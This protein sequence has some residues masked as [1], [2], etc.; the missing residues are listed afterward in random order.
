MERISA[1]TDL[2]TPSGKFRYGSEAGG[3]PATPV[4]AEWLNILQEE[5]CNFVLAFL[6]SLDAADNT[7]LL[8]AVR[9][10]V[11]DYYTKPET[12]ALIAAV[13][14]GSP[15]A[16]NTLRKLAAA[17]GNDPNF[18]TSV[19]TRFD[20]LSTTVN[21][22]LT[23]FSNTVTGWLAE[24]APLASPVFTGQPKAPT[25][26]AG[27]KSKLLATTEYVQ[28]A[29]AAAH[30]VGSLYFNASNSANPLALL[31]FGTWQALGAGR[32]L[33]GVGTGT[34]ARGEARAFAAGATG[35]EYSHVLTAAEMPSHTHPSP[36]GSVTPTGAGNYSSGD[37]TTSTA[38]A[39]PPS[40]STGGD[41]PHN[42]LPPYLA[43]YMWVRT[44]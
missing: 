26:A 27:D 42:N 1:F 32:M 43:V 18:S 34:D 6:P 16:L 4:K 30:P 5:L 36:Q 7:Q 40:G 35:G 17:V 38:F 8:K 21:N 37:D 31:G 33:I 29:L 3:V 24:K 10:L 14:D 12:D 11:L 44:S 9:K 19:S 41:Q 20:Q 22:W 2:C 23:Q 28:T 15:A 25:P 39:S 13:V